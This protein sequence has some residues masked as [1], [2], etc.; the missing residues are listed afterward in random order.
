LRSSELGKL[1]PLHDKAISVYAGSKRK[2]IPFLGKKLEFVLVDLTETGHE[3]PAAFETVIGNFLKI[4]ESQKAEVAK[5]LFGYFLDSMPEE[6]E[7]PETVDEIWEFHRMWNVTVG[8][9][10]KGEFYAC[11]MSAFKCSELKSHQINFKDGN[12]F[13]NITDQTESPIS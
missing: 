11:I 8:Q 12:E 7:V 2:L 5:H 9:N 1:R 13:I 4:E 3:I 10:E 6:E